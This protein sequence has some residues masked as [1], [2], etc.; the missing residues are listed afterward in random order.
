MTD[1]LTER[2]TWSFWFGV[3]DI[4]DAEA[5]VIGDRLAE[6]VCPAHG[7]KD[8]CPIVWVAVQKP[9]EDDEPE[10]ITFGL[11]HWDS[12]ADHPIRPKP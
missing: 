3:Q 11:P 5:E 2:R 1:P 8:D 10:P 4:T 6:A 9:I 7:P 12:T